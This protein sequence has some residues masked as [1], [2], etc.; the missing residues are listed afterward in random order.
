[1]T[2]KEYNEMMDKYN[3]HM[4]IQANAVKLCQKRGCWA[5]K[6]QIE[7]A[8]YYGLASSLSRY[9]KEFIKDG[10]GNSS[11]VAYVTGNINFYQLQCIDKHSRLVRIPVRVTYIPQDKKDPNDPFLYYTEYL[12]PVEGG[13]FNEEIDEYEDNV[14]EEYLPGDD[15]YLFDLAVK[16]ILSTPSFNDRLY[17]NKV[18]AYKQYYHL[19]EYHDTKMLTKEIME[20]NKLQNN[21][22]NDFKRQT[23][24]RIKKRFANLKEK[25]INIRDRYNQKI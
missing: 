11:F 16:Q 20:E 19:G 24:A 8:G 23:N 13:G 12:Q 17:E 15:K 10:S 1:M 25:Y 9:N 18:N 22:F 5:F 21:T 2:T 7:S 6:D 14:V 4:Y 3:F